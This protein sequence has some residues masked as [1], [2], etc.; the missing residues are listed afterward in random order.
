MKKPK[1]GRKAQPEAKA[2]KVAPTPEPGK[3]S[4]GEA[5]GALLEDLK[6]GAIKKPAPA[7]S[8]PPSPPPT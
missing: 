7:P 6:A 4:E 5:L 1:K 3:D 2:P 8:E